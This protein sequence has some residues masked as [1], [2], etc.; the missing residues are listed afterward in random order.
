MIYRCMRVTLVSFQPKNNLFV[1]NKCVV[2]LLCVMVFLVPAKSQPALNSH[3]A[4]VFAAFKK[5]LLNT[6]AGNRAGKAINLYRD[7]CRGL[8]EATAMAVLDNVGHL[9]R[10]L[11]DRQL[12]WCLFQLRADYYAHHR[13]FNRLSVSYHQQG[14]DY[15]VSHHMP[16]ETG[17]SLH[18]QGLFYFKFNYYSKACLC[19]LRAYDKFKEAG[20]NH[21]SH[22]S[23][24]LAEQA[25]FYYLLKDY[26]K[27]TILLE[28][29]L[30]CPV[31]E[32][33]VHTSLTNTMG[34]IYRNYNQFSKAL[35]YFNQSLTIARAHSD[36]AMIGISMGNIGSVYFMQNNYQKA[37]PYLSVAYLTCQ[38]FREEG[39]SVSALLFMS[40]ISLRTG[41]LKEAEIRLDSAEQLMLKS[42]NDRLPHYLDLY[43]QKTILYQKTGKL[44]PALVYAEKYETVNDSLAARENRVAVERARLQWEIDK[45]HNQIAQ[46]QVAAQNET[47][48]RNTII[49][50]L[51]LLIVIF[52]LVF[53]RYR[54]K[55]KKNKELL[56]TKKRQVDKEL[57]NATASL[58]LYTESLKQSNV[59]I[60]QFKAEIDLFKEHSNNQER[61]EHLE[62]LMQAHIMTDE[63]WNE[64]KKLFN[65]VHN[66]F[67]L[68]LRRK[69]PYLTDTDMRL[70][71]LIKLGLNNKEMANMLGITIEGIKKAKQR[72]RKKMQLNADTGF[73]E[74]LAGF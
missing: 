43:K 60:E 62:A 71:S 25:R 59:L 7:S 20:F 46:L 12:E 37:L 67:F 69:F 15:A 19:F 18:K 11:N 26:D 23:R 38:K 39:S 31:K 35:Y 58:Q 3:G 1:F 2:G 65:Q 42:R 14:I 52:I 6:H 5:C 74:I 45:Y 47:F 41:Q 9:A 28:I 57:E 53:N 22:I 55:A 32:Q 13:G 27:A 10:Q 73:E 63:T 40:N 72:L 51:F 8:D 21:V 33:R 64:F 16:I 4:I 70:L 68:K 66:G 29:A 48:K 30:A 44:K 49:F 17:M 54:L 56:L 61:A 24:Y 36:S 34:L 50:I